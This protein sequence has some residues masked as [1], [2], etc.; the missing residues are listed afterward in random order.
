MV[1]QII[2]SIFFGVIA[3]FFVNYCCDVLPQTRR[4][5]QPACPK[6]EQNQTWMSYLLF[7]PCAQCHRSAAMRRWVILGIYPVIFLALELFP[8]IRLNVWVAAVLLIYLGVVTIIDLEYRAVMYEEIAV[9]VVLASAIGWR[10]HGLWATL[11]GGL[12]GLG[13]FMAIYLFGGLFARWMARLRNQTTDEEGMGFGDVLLSGVLGLM[14]GWPGIIAGIVFAIVAGG[15]F[16]GVYLVILLIQRKYHLFTA[17][18][19]APFL[20]LGAIILLFRP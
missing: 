14:L 3:A 12:A 10:L 1:L 11:L 5:S 9:G 8:P 20:V 4:L 16:S 6:C 19:Y 17:I 2:V 7:K 15:L 13:I 18:P